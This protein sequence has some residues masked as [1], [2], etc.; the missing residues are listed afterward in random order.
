MNDAKITSV[1]TC[2]KS[3]TKP[4]ILKWSCETPPVAKYAIRPMSKTTAGI[5][6]PPK[7]PTL[8]IR[9]VSFVP[10]SCVSVNPQTMIATPMNIT[11]GLL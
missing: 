4:F 9:A 8:A 10:P 5:K 7:K 1:L 6:T 2:V 3:G 11:S